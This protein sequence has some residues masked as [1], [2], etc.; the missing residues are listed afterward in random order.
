M[1]KMKTFIPVQLEAVA[2]CISIKPECS[3]TE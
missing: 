1:T 2:K 3:E